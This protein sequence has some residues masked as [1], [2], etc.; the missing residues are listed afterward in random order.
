MIIDSTLEMCSVPKVSTSTVYVAANMPALITTNVYP[1]TLMFHGINH[2]VT[3]KE[4]CFGEAHKVLNKNYWLLVTFMGPNNDNSFLVQLMAWSRT[5]D[6]P[7]FDTII[8]IYGTWHQRVNLV[9]RGIWED[10]SHGEYKSVAT[11]HRFL[12]Y[13]TLS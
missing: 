3:A 8:Y 6:N 10:N 11:V 1:L 5:G 7:L 2:G 4:C 13:H 12:M 9:T